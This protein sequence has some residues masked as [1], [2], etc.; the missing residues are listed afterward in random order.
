MSWKRQGS[1]FNSLVNSN[2]VDKLSNPFDRHIIQTYELP[3]S[4]GSGQVATKA[5]A[6]IEFEKFDSGVNATNNQIIFENIW[7]G[8]D[9][10]ASIV[11]EDV[12]GAMGFQGIRFQ[13][14]IGNGTDISQNIFI[15]DT[16]GES[17]LL[18]L[19]VDLSLNYPFSQPIWEKPPTS[20]PTN[21]GCPSPPTLVTD[22]SCGTLGRIRI[23]M[24]KEVPTQTDF[25]A[26]IRALQFSKAIGNPPSSNWTNPPEAQYQKIEISAES[27]GE[28]NDI[29]M[30]LMWQHKEVGNTTILYKPEPSPETPISH[31]TSTGFKKWEPDYTLFPTVQ[32]GS[33]NSGRELADISQNI[34]LKDTSGETLLFALDVSKDIRADDPS[35]N[36]APLADASFGKII[37]PMGQLWFQYPTQANILLPSD[38]SNPCFHP[39]KTER[40]QKFIEAVNKTWDDAPPENYIEIK[41]EESTDISG[42]AILYQ[43]YGGLSGNTNIKYDPSFNEINANSEW[44]PTSETSDASFNGGTTEYDISQNL[45]ITNP[46]SI[47]VTFHLNV[48]LSMNDVSGN[49]YPPFLSSSNNVQVQM[50]GSLLDETNNIHNRITNE[51]RAAHFTRAINNTPIIS[52]FPISWGIS[53]IRDASTVTLL[54]DYPGINGNGNISYDPSFAEISSNPNHY[55]I[56][57]TTRPFPDPSGFVGGVDPVDLSQ[58]IILQA[59]ESALH[60]VTI[61]G[62]PA[63]NNIKVLFLLD[64]DKTLIQDP[65]GPVD[66]SGSPAGWPSF[67]PGHDIWSDASFVYGINIPMGKGLG[68]TSQEISISDASRAYKFKEGLK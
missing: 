14:S 50:D 24:G 40:L 12:S 52:G 43:M 47:S 25:I 54:Q 63:L 38:S 1:S 59:Y 15:T 68:H 55:P 56:C 10:S 27:L 4:S 36:Q 58:N 21:I 33:F 22:A 57:S 53:A 44:L 28:I 8:V 60:P 64:V 23:Q 62:E 11:F 20:I 2:Y 13:D 6:A 17:L 48:D 32:D 51:E 30:C 67:P 9:A 16:S 42:V 34:I 65:L 31:W 46:N 18:V 41:A 45:T 66:L 61:N 39:N 19:D 5:I 35:W 7:H 37:I 3:D 49:Y 26:Q 29:S